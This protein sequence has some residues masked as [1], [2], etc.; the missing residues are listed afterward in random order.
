MTKESEGESTTI[1]ADSADEKNATSSGAR[2]ESAATEQSSTS[3]GAEG[4]PTNSSMDGKRK[5]DEGP[6]VGTKSALSTADSVTATS[7]ENKPKRAKIAMPPSCASSLTNVEKYT[8]ESPPPPDNTND[9]DAA[10][11]ITSPN[12]MLFGLHPLIK[13]PP[14]EK[15][16]EDYGTVV[17]VTVRSAFASRYGHVTFQTV[18]EA[19]KCY[20]AIHGAKLLHKTFMVQPGARVPSVASSTTDSAPKDEKKISDTKPTETKKSSDSKGAG[21]ATTATLV[22]TSN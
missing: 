20:S 1:A 13:A 10:K 2:G 17:A 15:M 9:A 19:Q 22:T 18:E 5:I 8:L 11:K 14:L 6:T 12:L 16:L 3:N 21:A 7:I 4:P